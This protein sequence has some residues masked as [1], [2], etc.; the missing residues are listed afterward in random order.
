M[1]VPARM[2]AAVFHGGRDIRVTEVDTPT[3]ARARC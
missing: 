2:S 3:P 1:T